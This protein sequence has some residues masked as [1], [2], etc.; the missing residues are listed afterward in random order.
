MS[1]HTRVP[2]STDPRP[3]FT[4]I[5][6]LVVISIIS[7]LMAILLPALG[8]ARQRAQVIQ[9][10]TQLRQIG[11]SH[12][13]YA[14]AHKDW[15]PIADYGQCATI[16]MDRGL[17]AWSN[18]N[19]TIRPWYG[20]NVSLFKCPGTIIQTQT[21]TPRVPGDDYFALYGGATNGANQSLYTAGLITSYRFAAARGSFRTTD[22]NYGLSFYGLRHFVDAT[23]VRDERVPASV[24][25]LSFAGRTER[26]PGTGQT[27]YIHPPSNQVM[28]AD[29]R[30]GTSDLWVPINAQGVLFNNHIKIG[31]TANILFLDGRVKTA[32]Q[33]V[34][35]ATERLMFHGDNLTGTRRLQW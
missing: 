4:L 1:T 19:S 7:I 14:D 24:P 12:L 17:G 29:A 3:A 28:A 26:D 8:A 18:V 32:S 21:S 35:A 5:E 9:C 16:G 23:G 22:G 11:M 2:A 25:R 31:P 20:N 27:I 30:R 6:L 10:G 15:F 33:E 13:M 34:G